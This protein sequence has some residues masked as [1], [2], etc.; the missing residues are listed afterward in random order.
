MSRMQQHD[1]TEQMVNGSW[2]SMNSLLGALAMIMPHKK[3]RDSNPNVKEQ[4][5]DRCANTNAQIQTHTHT[6]THT[7]AHRERNIS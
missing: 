4:I 2:G 5:L 1:A 3:H 6:H 7:H